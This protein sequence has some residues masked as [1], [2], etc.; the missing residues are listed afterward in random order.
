MMSWALWVGLVLYVV[1]LV[2][3]FGLRSVLQY[4]ATGDSGHRRPHHRPGSVGWWAAVLLAG[5]VGVGAVGPLLALTGAVG[6]PAVLAVPALAGGGLVLMVC[7]FAG[8]LAG[9][10]AMGLSWRV[11]VDD[12]ERTALVSAG[13]FRHVRNPIFTAMVVAYIGLLATVPTWVTALGLV[14]LIAGVELQVRQVEEP[15]LIRVH[16]AAYRRYAA[17]VGRFLPRLG[18][19]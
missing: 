3:V 17:G 19:L 7:G 5:A 13:L 2:T 6:V 12:T 15:Y 11:G 14:C 16:G 18:R 10:Q 9:Q 1:G 4:R 8:V